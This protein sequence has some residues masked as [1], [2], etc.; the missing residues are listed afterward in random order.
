MD[1]H[2][3]DAMM[4]A[5]CRAT[6]AMAGVAQLCGILAQRHV[7]DRSDLATIHDI[8]DF[9]L[10]PGETGDLHAE[11]RDLLGSW[12]GRAHDL[13]PVSLKLPGRP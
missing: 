4:R 1:D 8:M 5:E 13:A 3:D 2:P 6:A 9:V 12:F 7:I 11:A 10:R